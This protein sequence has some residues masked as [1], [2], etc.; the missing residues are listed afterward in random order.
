[1]GFRLAETGK[2]F[3]I[4]STGWVETQSMDKVCST[5]PEAKSLWS[6]L[7]IDHPNVGQ[8]RTPKIQR[9]EIAPERNAIERPRER[10]PVLRNFLYSRVAR[11]R[12]KFQVS[13]VVATLVS[14]GHK[15]LPASRSITV[16][17]R[18]RPNT[19]GG[20]LKECRSRFTIV[21]WPWGGSRSARAK[22][23]S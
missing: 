7:D 18:Y 4:I 21:P 12:Q 17:S 3:V 5:K 6:V 15:F 22:T 2:D 11:H 23:L 14:R 13:P 8:K 19:I 9:I 1:M 16:L 20:K 10:G